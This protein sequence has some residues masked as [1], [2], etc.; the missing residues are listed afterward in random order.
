MII[1]LLQ[2]GGE[3][4]GTLFQAV[5]ILCFAI[6]LSVYLEY[7]L[8]FIAI[9][10]ATLIALVFFF[11]TRFSNIQNKKVDRITE[12]ATKLAVEALTNIK[13]VVSLGREDKFYELYTELLR[14]SYRAF[15]NDFSIRCLVYSLTRFFMY[16]TAGVCI[17]YGATLVRDDNLEIGVVFKYVIKKSNESF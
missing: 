2:G 13:T 1:L 7:R 10:M 9:V 4:I 12:T 6:F 3:K 11:H 15:I 8:G 5:S 14:P 17:Y 16:G